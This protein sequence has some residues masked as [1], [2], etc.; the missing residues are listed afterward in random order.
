MGARVAAPPAVTERDFA[1]PL[2]LGNERLFALRRHVELG[3]HKIAGALSEALGRPYDLRLDDVREVHAD[4]ATEGL[5]EP[6]AALSF[7]VAGQIGWA[8]WDRQAAVRAV[9]TLLCGAPS[10]K[11]DRGLSE[12]ETALVAAALQGLVQGLAER[13]GVVIQDAAPA[14]TLVALGA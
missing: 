13:A 5:E 6:L 12:L 14:T 2:R 9:E 3:L 10:R 8:V 7:R 4:L 11:I 1:R